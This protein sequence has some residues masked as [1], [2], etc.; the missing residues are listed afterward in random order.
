MN[1]DKQDGRFVSYNDSTKKYRVEYKMSDSNKWEQDDL[2]YEELTGSVLASLQ[3]IVDEQKI[4][5]KNRQQAVEIFTISDEMYK[6]W[7][8]EGDTNSELGKFKKL[9]PSDANSPYTDGYRL[10]CYTDQWKC[11][12][13]RYVKKQIED[14]L[15][16]ITNKHDYV[17][18]NCVILN[19]TSRNCHPQQLHT[20][21]KRGNEKKGAQTDKFFVVIAIDKDQTLNVL[22]SPNKPHQSYEAVCLEKILYLLESMIVFMEDQVIRAFISMLCLYR[23]VR[24]R[25]MNLSLISS[26][27]NSC[28]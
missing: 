7:K 2:Y 4:D 14:Q 16:I 12:R 22:T 6:R 23:L 26:I 27:N 20:D 24:Y 11:K 13:F 15:K 5:W 8:S 18:C 9:D 17:L 19:T 3:R 1:G 28:V 10:Q 21:W 25:Q